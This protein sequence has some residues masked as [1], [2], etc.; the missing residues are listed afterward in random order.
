MGV[1]LKGGVLVMKM[2][3]K[4]TGAI[5]KVKDGSPVPEDEYVVFLVKDRA[6]VE[7]GLPAYLQ[8]CI[9]LGADDVQIK[10]VEEMRIRAEQWQHD[11]PDR[12]KVPD[13]AGEM[14]LP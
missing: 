2:D 6:F 11:H 12:V 9:E 7:Y 4:F 10:M 3:K 1:L 14:R 13:A 5:V 8:G